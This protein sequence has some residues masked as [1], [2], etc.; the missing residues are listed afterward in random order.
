MCKL[1]T[2]ASLPLFHKDHHFLKI[3]IKTWVQDIKLENINIIN[4]LP[5]I[6]FLSSFNILLQTSHVLDIVLK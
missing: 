6:L 2:A 4:N 1:K 5:L 3:K